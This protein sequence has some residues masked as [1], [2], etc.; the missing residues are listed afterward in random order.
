MRLCVYAWRE[1]C[2][3]CLVN[4]SIHIKCHNQVGCTWTIGWIQGHIWGVGVNGFT[5]SP[6]HTHTKCWEFRLKDVATKCVLRAVNASTQNAFAAY[7]SAAQTYRWI[8]GRSGEVREGKGMKRK[9]RE[10]RGKSEGRANSGYG[11]GWILHWSTECVSGSTSLNK[12]WRIIDLI[13]LY[14]FARYL[15]VVLWMSKI[16]IFNSIITFTNR[17]LLA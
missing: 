8:W 4:F 12:K 3:L 2:P 9:G 6:P 16:P 11:L 7:C 1:T 10:G 17:C 13:A 5:T 15:V 14:A